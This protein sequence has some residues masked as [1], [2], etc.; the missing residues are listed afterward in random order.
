[1]LGCLRELREALRERGGD[2]VIRTGPPRARAARR[3][4]RRRARDAPLRLRRLALRDG[5]RPARRGRTSASRWCA[6]PGLFVADVGKP[7][8]KDG[9]P[10]SVFSPF[11]RAWEQLDAARGARRAAHARAPER[12]RPSAGSRALESDVPEPF[13]PG[14][15]AARD[16][17]HAWLRDG[18]DRYA[19]RHDR[20]E[21]GTSRAL[22]L[23]ALRLR[24]AARARG[25]GAGTGGGGRPRSC[26][27][28]AW[29]D[30]Y[31][32]VLLN[33]PGNAH[34]AHQA[35]MDDARVGGRRRG[36]RGVVRGPHRL[37]GGRRRDAPAP[38]PRMDAQP[39]AAD[40]RARS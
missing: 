18:I 34:H 19:D 26:R 35:A 1:M 38:R 28:L 23:P 36:L 37:P 11:W 27:Q 14:E 7:R 22:A 2:L 21:G 6:I 4:R 9:K 32:H 3:W 40:R 15:K 25:A 5:A 31:A 13:A 10:F 20:L 39:R 30:F 17:M 24:L 29:R 33:N 8:T 16:R 12:G